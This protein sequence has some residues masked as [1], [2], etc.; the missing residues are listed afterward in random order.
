[1]V[2]QH[3]VDVLL[4][5]TNVILNGR[6]VCVV[7]VARE[8]L[9]QQQQ[10][11]ALIQ[12]LSRHKLRLHVVSSRYLHGSR[13]A[14]VKLASVGLQLAALAQNAAIQTARVALDLGECKRHKCSSWWNSK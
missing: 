8:A 7:S 13:K 14:A 6:R 5:A 3:A 9:Q 2:E 12:L 1:M 10:Q 4:H 11:E